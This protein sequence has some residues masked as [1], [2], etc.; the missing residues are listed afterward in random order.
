MRTKQIQSPNPS[1][2]TLYFCCC[3]EAGAPNTP[4]PKIDGLVVVLLDEVPAAAVLPKADDPKGD[5]CQ[6]ECGVIIVAS[7][8]LNENANPP[9]PE[10][11]VLFAV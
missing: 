3:D 11:G 5:D 1:L 6:P 8:C 4:P 10:T 7:V 9:D 2:P